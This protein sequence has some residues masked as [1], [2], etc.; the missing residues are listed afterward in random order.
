MEGGNENE[1]E[2]CR[3]ELSYR[4][5]FPLP[6]LDLPND[7]ESS[8]SF[9]PW[10][11]QWDDDDGADTPETP[12]SDV[13]RRVLPSYLDLRRT[14]NIAF[15]DEKCRE[16]NNLLESAGNDA[17]AKDSFTKALDLVP[18]HLDSL[19]GYAKL[20]IKT[21]KFSKAEGFLKSALRLDATN[22]EAQQ[23][24]AALQRKRQRSFQG[25]AGSS[26]SYS[27]VGGSNDSKPRDSS[28]HL[29]LLN[30]NALNKSQKNLTAR[31]S[32]AY[33]DALMERS[34]HTGPLLEE[35]GTDDVDND[36]DSSS[37]DSIHD[38]RSERDDRRGKKKSKR[39]DR[40]RRRRDRHRRDKRKRSRSSRSRK[41]R[42][43][44]KKHKKKR[45]SRRHTRDDVSS[46]SY[47]SSESSLYSSSF[48]SSSSE[49]QSSVPSVI[50]TRSQ[51]GTDVH[52]RKLQEEASRSK[53]TGTD[54]SQESKHKREDSD[55]AAYD[56]HKHEGDDNSSRY[57]KK[58]R[59]RRHD[60]DR[61]RRHKRFKDSKRHKKRKDDK[62]RGTKD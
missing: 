3:A 40:D 21:G 39:H 25:G 58:R 26:A 4:L 62:R 8:F 53:S 47:S 51:K 18:E 17:K 52:E 44:E 2:N 24:L 12:A 28:H 45:S 41:H 38:E 37:H 50:S 48:Y 46:H 9:V 33:K 27:L 57:R 29:L 31:K 14:Q 10:E 16:A 13:A 11:I 49:S 35:T 22:A 6:K 61:K 30:N 5:C 7:I 34:L 43:K 42:S 54:Q 56:E 1:N 32:S 60:E 36:G 19:I 20:L 55:D 23:C 59:R 15:A